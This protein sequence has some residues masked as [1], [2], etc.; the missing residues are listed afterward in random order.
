MSGEQRAES[1]GTILQ[2]FRS[3]NL[4]L[5]RNH[6]SSLPPLAESGGHIIP[7]PPLALGLVHVLVQGS[8]CRH[9]CCRDWSWRCWD[10]CRWC[11]VAGCRLLWE[12][13]HSSEESLDARGQVTHSRRM[14]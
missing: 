5:A 4:Y 9:W 3:T 14:Q 7:P 13:Q 1:R 6:T 2:V 8:W 12:R 11:V 10:R